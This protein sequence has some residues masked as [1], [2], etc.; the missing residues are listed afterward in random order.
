MAGRRAPS[1]PARPKPLSGT[2][3]STAWWW[4]RMGAPPSGRAARPWRSCGRRSAREGGGHPLAGG[5]RAPPGQYRLPR[6]RDPCC[7]CLVDR[8]TDAPGCGAQQRI[9]LAVTPPLRRQTCAQVV[10]VCMASRGPWSRRRRACPHTGVGVCNGG[11]P[12]AGRCAQSPLR[13]A[14]WGRLYLCGRA[15]SRLRDRLDNGHGRRCRPHKTAGPRR[16]IV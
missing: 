14:L 12:P 5:P 7:V 8:P 10:P 15:P 9:R 1:V 4:Q 11:A 6:A 3:R 13:V 2:W 16:P